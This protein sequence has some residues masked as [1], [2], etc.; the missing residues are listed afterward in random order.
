MDKRRRF[1]DSIENRIVNSSNIKKQMNAQTKS[2]RWFNEVIS[3]LTRM[4]TIIKN[5]IEI[6][7]YE[8][9]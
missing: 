4:G 6:P 1:T 7:I 2:D 5:G 8:F 9:V 3:T